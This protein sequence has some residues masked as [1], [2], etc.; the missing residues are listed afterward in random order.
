MAERSRGKSQVHNF[1]SWEMFYGKL[2]IMDNA[3]KEIKRLQKCTE[4][5]KENST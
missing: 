2:E 4:R 3:V 5:N 1:I